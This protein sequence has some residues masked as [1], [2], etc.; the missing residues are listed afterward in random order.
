MAEAAE[1][2]ACKLSGLL[3]TSWDILSG[4]AHPCRSESSRCVTASLVFVG[5]L[6]TM[7]G[8]AALFSM[9]QQAAVRRVRA[10][11]S[12]VVLVVR[13]K[14]SLSNHSSSDSNPN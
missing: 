8:Y 7:Y 6:A 9:A 14:H 2:A 3:K 1:A 5:P 10:I 11:V 12:V 13:L 4:E